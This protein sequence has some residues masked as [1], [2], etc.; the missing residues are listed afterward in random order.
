MTET[1]N[2][3]LSWQELHQD[4]RHLAAQLLAQQ[5]PQLPWQGII[6]I[7]RGGLVPGAILAREL[8]IRL[9]D[10]LCIASYEHDQ[11]GP[12]RV[13]KSPALVE[14]LGDGAGYLLVDDLVDTG[15]TAQLAKQLL[16]QALFATLYAKPQGR[17]LADIFVREF[18]QQTWLHFPWDSEV[19]D[20]VYHYRAPMIENSVTTGG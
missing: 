10:T 20:E 9:V 2:H 11:Q 1:D 15:A 3:F 19:D 4:C 12:A 16:P 6:C 14:R 7:A 17:A 5:S 13:L 8:D 18:S